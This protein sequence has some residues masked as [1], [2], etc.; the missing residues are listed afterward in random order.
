[1]NFDNPADVMAEFAD[2]RRRID[3]LETQALLEFSSI[4]GGD[5]LKVLTPEGIELKDG[6]SLKAGE[7]SIESEGGGRVGAGGTKI[8]ADG[9]IAN[10]I[11]DL[12]IASNTTFEGNVKS[13]GTVEAVN[14]KASGEVEAGGT[15]IRADGSLW[16]ADNDLVIASNTEFA[17]NATAAG[18]VRGYQGVIAP[19]NG[20]M[21]QLGPAIAAAQ[22]D[23]DSAASAAAAAQSTADGKVGQSTFSSEVARL[24]GYIEDLGMVDQAIADALS[25]IRATYNAH[26]DT[27][28]P[29]APKM[30]S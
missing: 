12:K 29:G 16:N 13:D 3:Q 22:A 10:D 15:K 11:N 23:A 1:M 24:E 6:G 20:T 9:K 7:A 26:V 4:S 14:V 21:S 28:H 2:L 5:G 25:A 30:N 27:Y 18:A 8:R 17:G 19:I